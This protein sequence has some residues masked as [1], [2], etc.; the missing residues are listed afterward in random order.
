MRKLIEKRK[1]K[2]FKLLLIYICFIKVKLVRMC[3]SKVS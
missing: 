1:D 3:I 2:S